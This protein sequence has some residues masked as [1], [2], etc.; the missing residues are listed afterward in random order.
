MFGNKIGRHEFQ[1]ALDAIA[2]RYDEEIE[3]VEDAQIIPFPVVYK[4]HPSWN[5]RCD[6]DG[7]VILT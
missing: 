7:N 3:V 1:S 5:L 6:E 2:E 4:V